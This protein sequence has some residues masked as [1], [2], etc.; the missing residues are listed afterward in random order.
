MNAP[1]T[2]NAR[3][4]FDL[5]LKH[6]RVSKN[7]DMTCEMSTIPKDK[8]ELKH[9]HNDQYQQ[10]KIESG[11]AFQGQTANI[12]VYNFPFGFA[13]QEQQADFGEESFYNV[14]GYVSPNDINLDQ[15]RQEPLGMNQ[16]NASEMQ[17][18]QFCSQGL[19]IQDLRKY[20]NTQL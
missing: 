8:F 17:D 15:L 6:P 12:R 4:S 5:Y 7:T 2:G 9:P 10:L 13:D 16:D 1:K 14:N 20:S 18:G 3:C 11:R 19:V